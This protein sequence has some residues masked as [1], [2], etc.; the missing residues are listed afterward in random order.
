MFATPSLSIPADPTSDRRTDEILL[1]D[2]PPQFGAQ[3]FSKG[4]GIRVDI[5]GLPLG[6]GKGYYE[7]VRL[8]DGFCQR[9][10]NAALGQTTGSRSRGDDWLKIDLYT[11]GVQ[12][13]VFAGKGQVDFNR[14]WCNV[15]YHPFGLDKG[16]WISS[17]AH[18]QGTTLY[19]SR[20]FVSQ[21]FEHDETGVPQG[22]AP[23]LE[24]DREGF[25]FE[26]VGVSSSMA[27][28]LFELLNAPYFGGLRRLYF[29]S[30]GLDILAAAFASMGGRSSAGCVQ[31]KPRDRDRIL[32]AKAVL[33]EHFSD[34][35][36]VL[37]L[38]RR[39]GVNQRKLKFGFKQVVGATI[40]DYC[41]ELR[42]TSAARLLGNRDLSITQV[43]LEVGY[44]FPTNFATA[45]K[46]RFGMSP[47]RFRN[48]AGVATNER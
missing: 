12:S 14:A 1:C 36:C 10:V 44:E 26:Q 34:P 40:S 24:G 41:Q 4:I 3:P 5:A 16:E 7:F 6:D 15:H 23:F 17:S 32:A 8:R 20:A 11:S 38:S 29:E 22:L 2:P 21:L 39:V 47:Q 35:P 42:L 25:I 28:S 46:R 48:S 37:E 31:L 30:R 45:F 43:A 33:D 13:L 27:R 19:V 9:V 18:I